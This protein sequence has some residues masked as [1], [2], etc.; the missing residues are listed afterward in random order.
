MAP[1]TS[2]AKDHSFEEIKNHKDFVKRVPVRSYEEFKPYI[3][4]VK[5]GETNVLWP[6]KPI[7][8]A[9]TSGTT[10]G[11]KYIPITTESAPAHINS[12]RDAMCHYINQTGY[13]GFLRKKIIFL[14]GS[15]EL[16]EENG[17]KTGRLS[18][19]TAHLTPTY[20]KKNVM[21]SWEINC[22]KD[23]EKKVHRIASNTG[24]KS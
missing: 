20:L 18:G 11:S 2:F 23:W 5:L 3:E 14:Q 22:I 7:Y 10:S 8:F 12:S 17:I 24:F 15:P 1:K 16:E 19:I 21:P 13:T 9:K 4:R 6:G